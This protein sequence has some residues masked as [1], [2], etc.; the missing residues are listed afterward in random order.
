MQL[1]DLFRLTFTRVRG[2]ALQAAAQISN[3]AFD[4]HWDEIRGQF[5]FEAVSDRPYVSDARAI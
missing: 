1:I 3:S 2:P 4:V 5:F